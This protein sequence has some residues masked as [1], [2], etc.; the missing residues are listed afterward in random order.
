M[1]A[2]D[3]IELGTRPIRDDAPAGAPARDEP[4]FEALQLEVRKLELPEQPTPNWDLAVRSAATLLGQKSKD[5]LVASYLSVGLLEKEGYDGL[6]AGLTILRDLIVT[7]WDSLF[8]EAKRMRGR[9][10]AIEWLAERGAP[11]VRR[12]PAGPQHEEAIA[13]ALARLGE[14]GEQLAPRMEGGGSLLVELRRALEEAAERSKSPAPAAAT[15]AA[16]SGASAG[17]A[18]VE[19]AGDLDA[20]L[21]EAKR[22]LRA[23]GDFLRKTDPKNPLGYR[24]PRLVAWMSVAQLPPNAGGKTQIPAPQPPDFGDKLEQALGAGQWAGVI[25][26]AEGRFPNAVLWL[27][28][29]RYSAAALEGMGDE[30]APAAEAIA[31]EVAVLLRR[32]PGL[33]ELRFANDQPLASAATQA[34]IRE[35]VAPAAAGAA[36]AAPAPAAAAA[37]AGLAGFDEAKREAWQLARGRKLAA[38]VARLEE[39]ASRAAALRD[40]VPWKLEIARICLDRGHAE[41]ALAQLEALDVE[42]TRASVEAWD[43]VLCADVIKSLL[44]CRQKV[45]SSARQATPDDAARSREL[46]GRL[47]RLDVVAALEM[48]GKR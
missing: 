28:L 20:A 17:P 30:Y 12:A 31:Q 1:S 3:L 29:H 22:L 9:I 23:S 18:A 21:A 10:A 33:A 48:N 36:P 11:R 25:E 7:F 40:R 13:R 6:A 44:V 15:A 27:D 24:M 32:V 45:L 46:M 43:P 2:A 4:E 16:S 38:A 39:G 34:W 14:L 35:R 26:Q 42:L 8:P 47:C 37:G 19:S 5:L 41:T